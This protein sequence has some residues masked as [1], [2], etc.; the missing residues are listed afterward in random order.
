[1]SGN[2]LGSRFNWAFAMS[3]SQLRIDK[4]ETDEK[5]AGGIHVELPEIG[6]VCDE[7]SYWITVGE[8][9]CDGA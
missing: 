9:N 1:M 4:D 3:K 7:I 5:L 8:T 2:R 6:I